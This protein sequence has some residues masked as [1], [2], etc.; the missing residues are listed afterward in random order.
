MAEPGITTFEQVL[1]SLTA[2]E[3]TVPPGDGP[4][5]RALAHCAQSIEYSM[6]GYPKLRAWPIRA[7]IGP[8][9]KRRFLSKGKMSHDLAAPI[10]GAPQ[11][12]PSVTLAEAAARLRK[13]IAA[14]RGFEGALQPHLAYGRCTKTEYEA[15][16]AMHVADHLRGVIA[17]S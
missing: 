17:K 5:P 6:T 8:L 4:V 2:L 9:V 13:A 16:H 11:I 12:D 3:R 15:L 10:A 1:Q 14:F 7:L